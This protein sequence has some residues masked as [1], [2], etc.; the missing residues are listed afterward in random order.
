MKFIL[1]S[2]LLVFC[3]TYVFSQSYIKLH[4]PEKTNFLQEQEI[5]FGFIFDTKF[6]KTIKKGKI[7]NNGTVLSKQFLKKINLKINGTPFNEK[8]C[9]AYFSDACLLNG[10]GKNIVFSY[11][12]PKDDKIIVSDTFKIKPIKSI[13]INQ[14]KLAYGNQYEQNFNVQFVDDSYQN[15]QNQTFINFL[16]LYN[17]SVFSNYGQKNTTITQQHSEN[18]INTHENMW[19]KTNN[20]LTIKNFD[21]KIN[22]YLVL[23]FKSSTFNQEIGVPISTDNSYTFDFSGKNASNFSQ[24]G[25]NGSNVQITILTFDSTHFKITIQQGNTNQPPIIFNPKVAKL[26]LNINGGNGFRGARGQDGQ[27][28]SDVQ[29]GSSYIEGRTGQNGTNGGDGGDGGNTTI[30]CSKSFAQYLNAVNINSNGG[31]AGAGG[32]GGRGGQH[33]FA[34][35]NDFNRNFLFGLRATR[36]V[37][38]YNGRNGRNGYVIHQFMD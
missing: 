34:S 23:R 36:G 5:P 15:I 20:L 18:Q 25:E 13:F 22:E 10:G 29:V 14:V 12:H 28:A 38:G 32:E 1:Y 7:F 27:N 19:V 3:Q 4:L 21:D 11:N 16:R 31:A 9:I 8:M 26:H 30:L 6:T 24:S 37:D 2:Y 35:Q 33:Q 17:L